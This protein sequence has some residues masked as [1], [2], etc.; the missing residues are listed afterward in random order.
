MCAL[1]FTS[2]CESG[3]GEPDETRAVKQIRHQLLVQVQAQVEPS[4]RHT[5]TNTVKDE[6]KRNESQ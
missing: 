6:N 4:Q 1:P 5:Q 2:L 3:E